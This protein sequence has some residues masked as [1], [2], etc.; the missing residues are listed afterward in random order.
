MSEG[1]LRIYRLVPDAPESDP[2][3]DLAPSVGEIVVR[4]QSPADARIVASEAQP[5]FPE[6]DAKPGDGVRTSFAS[7]VRNEKLYRVEEDGSGTFS[8]DGD[9]AVLKGLDAPSSVIKPLTD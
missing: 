4:A 8:T 1:D 2:G 5:D 3:W 9:R 7:A 6:V